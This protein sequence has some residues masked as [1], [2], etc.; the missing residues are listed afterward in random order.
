M[1]FHLNPF[2]GHNGGFK[3]LLTEYEEHKA[4]QFTFPTGN[5]SREVV[6]TAIVPLRQF[7]NVQVSASISV[8]AAQTV[9]FIMPYL[10]IA[11]RANTSGQPN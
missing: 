4:K 2:C 10:C 5:L 9:K 3:N 7:I 6:S 1:N 11:H 8:F